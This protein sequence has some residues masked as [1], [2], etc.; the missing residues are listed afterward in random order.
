MRSPQASSHAAAGHS[1]R[2]R[3]WRTR[4]STFSFHIYAADV[5]DSKNFQ[6]LTGRLPVSSPGTQS[7]NPSA[8]RYEPH[9]DLQQQEHLQQQGHALQELVP[10]S[11]DLSAL[12]HFD[13]ARVNAEG[14][15]QHPAKQLK[16][17][18][19]A[20]DRLLSVQRPVVLAHLNR[21]RSRHPHATPTQLVRKLEARYLAAVTA[22][23]AAVG[24]TAAVPGVGTAAALAL[25]SA[26][27]IGFLE[28]TALY[29]QSLAE[30]HGL[31][32][33]DPDRA[34]LLVLTL[35]VGDEGLTLLRRVTGQATG[36]AAGDDASRKT[37]W[38]DVI[39]SSL[40][41]Q[42]VGPVT[43]QVKGM[44]LRKA[45]SAGSASVIGK[46][47]PYG[48]GAVIG[49]T[50]NHML[51]R[52]VVA[53]SRTAF[54]L[55]PLVLP[56]IEP[57]APRTIRAPKAPKAPKALKE[58]TAPRDPKAPRDSASKRLRIIPRPQPKTAE[59][60]ATPGSAT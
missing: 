52:R 43:D 24:A 17:L 56:E 25:T 44:F 54:G 1:Q 46:A 40:P 47:L 7:G 26:E 4:G 13:A 51:A 14:D 27:T 33:T 50:G 39:G 31:T 42:L 37:F 23:G 59:G 3:P 45:A 35:L 60:P 36:K 41:R 48:L 9:P 58:P 30:L 21:I 5:H 53:R 8:S 16:F 55:P 18:D 34:R 57:R 15:P 12:T 28:T 20:V 11:Y 32:I 22:G 38:G 6:E 10:A 29:A 2:A 19:R 49:G